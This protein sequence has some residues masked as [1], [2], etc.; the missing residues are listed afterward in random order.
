VVQPR[1]RQEDEGPFQPNGSLPVT[2]EMLRNAS[3]RVPVAMA[4]KGEERISLFWRVFGGT[5]LSIVALV[6]VTL[7]Q[8]FTNS[9]GEIRSNVNHLTESRA[10]LIKTDEFNTRLTTVWTSIKELQAAQAAN[11][12]LKTKADLLEQQLKMADDE[13]KE[14][15]RQL[16]QL[17]ERQAAVEARQASVTSA[18]SH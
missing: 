16:Q 7:Y 1:D 18:T 11:A 17:R 3:N 9:L 2:V 15:A 12:A 6:A 8:Q 10:E 4:E 14:M 13:R 5:I